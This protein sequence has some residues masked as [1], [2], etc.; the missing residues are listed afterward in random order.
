MPAVMVPLIK[1]SF[2]LSIQIAMTVPAYLIGTG[3]CTCKLFYCSPKQHM[4]WY[5]VCVCV[6]LGNQMWFNN[7]RTFIIANQFSWVCV[8]HLHSTSICGICLLSKLC[9]CVLLAGQIA[10]DSAGCVMHS[11]TVHY[12]NINI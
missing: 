5:G 3:K 12:S 8:F 10:F 4:F 2:T 7:E 1:Y 9:V 6:C 11:I